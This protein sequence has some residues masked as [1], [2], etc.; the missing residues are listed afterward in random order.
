MKLYYFSGAL[1]SLLTS[2]ANISLRGPG[3]K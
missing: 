2:A 3:L 1:L